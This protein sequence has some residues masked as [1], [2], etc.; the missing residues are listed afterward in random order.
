MAQLEEKK[1]DFQTWTD[2]TLSYKFNQKFSIGGDLGSR[3]IISSKDW[4]MFYI[5]PKAR[6]V[7][8]PIFNTAGGLGY[9]Y[10][11]NKEVDDSSELRFYQDFHVNWPDLGFFVLQHRVRFEQRFF[12]YENLE[13]D[14]DA[15]TRYQV[16]LQSRDFHL[17]NAERPFYLNAM[18]EGFIPFNESAQ[19]RFVNNARFNAGLGKRFSEKLRLEFF[20]IWQKSRQLAEDGFETSEHIF[21]IKFLYNLNLIESN[22][23]N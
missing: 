5:R 8:S 19:E 22:E 6:Y 14:F 16:K 15:R 3:G 11:S 9:F 4:T 7:F 20:Y 1:I 10:T 12:N 18:V 13:N 2:L 21:R 23:E 17:F